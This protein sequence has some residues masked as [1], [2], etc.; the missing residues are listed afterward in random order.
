MILG[1]APCYYIFAGESA[2]RLFKTL[3][4]TGGSK[5]FETAVEKLSAYFAPKWNKEYEHYTCSCKPMHS[6]LQSQSIKFPNM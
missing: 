2:H 6:I 4:D 5:D 1:G 3:P